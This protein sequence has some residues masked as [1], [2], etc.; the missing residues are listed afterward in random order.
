MRYPVKLR[1]PTESGEMEIELLDFGRSISIRS[2]DTDQALDEARRCIEEMV[3]RYTDDDEQIPVPRSMQYWQTE[4][5]EAN[6]IW[7]LIDIHP[8][9]FSDE[10]ER[11]NVSISKR[12]L[13]RLDSQAKKM[14]KTRSAAIVQ[15]AMTYEADSL[16]DRWIRSAL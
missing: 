15:M 12:V 6:A 16:Y 9:F 13:A 2:L 14:G 4:K 1:C 8:D 7:S 5:K 11:I 3:V 10:M